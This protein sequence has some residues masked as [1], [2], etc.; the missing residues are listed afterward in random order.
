MRPFTDDQVADWHG[1]RHHDYIEVDHS[2]FEQENTFDGTL[3][4][5]LD[6]PELDVITKNYIDPAEPEPDNG[7]KGLDHWDHPNNEGRV[8]PHPDPENYPPFDPR[9]DP[10]L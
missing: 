4:P 3:E 7:L 2:M 9:N 5:E 8:I 10:Y 1:F 6:V